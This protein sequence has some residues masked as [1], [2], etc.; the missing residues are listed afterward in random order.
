MWFRTYLNKRS[1]MMDLAMDLKKNM[2][3]L[4]PSYPPKELAIFWDRLGESTNCS[5]NHLIT[6]DLKKWLKPPATYIAV[7]FPCYPR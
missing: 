1:Q 5:L 3:Y 2:T 6:R 7:L 4:V